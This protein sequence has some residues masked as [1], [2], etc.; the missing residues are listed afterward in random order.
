MNASARIFPGR[1]EGTTPSNGVGEA[2]SQVLVSLNN[3]DKV[4]KMK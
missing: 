1:K 4:F 3:S 2:R